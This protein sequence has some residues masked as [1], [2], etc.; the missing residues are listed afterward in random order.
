[1]GCFGGGVFDP[2]PEGADIIRG[3]QLADAWSA[4]PRELLTELVRA[5][6]GNP[7]PPA[8]SVPRQ[9][10]APLTRAAR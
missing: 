8:V 2:G 4:G 7:G 1:M 9:A 5:A 10:R 3:W 6:H